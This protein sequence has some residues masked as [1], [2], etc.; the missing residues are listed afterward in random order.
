[1]QAASVRRQQTLAADAEQRPGPGVV[2]R[3]HAGDRPR[4]G[5][6]GQPEQHGLGLVVGGVA[7]QDGPIRTGLVERRIPG[8]ARTG[9]EAATAPDAHR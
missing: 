1:M 7:E 6:P 2:P 4:P 3:T 5:T 8:V 9:L